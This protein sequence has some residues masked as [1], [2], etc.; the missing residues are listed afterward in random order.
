LIPV[1]LTLW[2]IASAWIAK[3]YSITSS[4]RASNEDGTV[5][6]SVFAVFGLIISSYLFGACTGIS[7]G[8]RG[9]MEHDRDGAGR[10]L[11]GRDR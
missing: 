5:S 7:A 10:L 11:Q 6:S 9:A 1:H 3:A 8:G 4:A 2:A